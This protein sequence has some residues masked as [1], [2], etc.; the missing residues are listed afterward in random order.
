MKIIGHKN[1]KSL[2]CQVSENLNSKLAIGQS[3]HSDKINR[4]NSKDK[5]YSYGTYN[6]YLQQCIQFVKWCKVTHKCKI[7]DECR[8]YVDDYLKKN[9]D[10]KKSPYT[11]K[12][13]ASAIAKLYGCLAYEFINTPKRLRKDI[14]R[15]RATQIKGNTDFERFCLCTGLRRREITALRGTALIEEN[16]QYYI[17]VHNGKGGRRRIAEIVGTEEEIEFVVNKMKKAEDQKVF[18]KIPYTDIHAMRAIYANRIYNKYARQKSEFRNERLIMYHNRVIKTYTSKNI[19]IKN[20][21][22]Y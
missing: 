11:I 17:A 15:S 9:I 10:E 13:Q 22:E 20:N 7:L 18:S 19:D 1:K 4:I 21:L 14:T 16:G 6:A 3:K 2:I 5:I 12:L 8:C